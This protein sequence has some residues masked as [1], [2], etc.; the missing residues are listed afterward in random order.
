[1]VRCESVLR[2]KMTHDD[3]IRPCKQYHSSFTLEVTIPLTFPSLFIN[4]LTDLSYQMTEKAM[5]II[6]L[7]NV[8]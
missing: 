3:S 7:S 4:H 5:L 1:M 2:Q 6:F 8:S